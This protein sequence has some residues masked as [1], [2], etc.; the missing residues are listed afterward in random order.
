LESRILSENARVLELRAEE[1]VRLANLTT[2]AAIQ[3]ALLELRQRYLQSA[4][5]LRTL[6]RPTGPTDTP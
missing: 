1:C 5:R 6:V 2:D 3:S 4:A